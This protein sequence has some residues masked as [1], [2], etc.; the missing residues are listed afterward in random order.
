MRRRAAEWIETVWRGETATARGVQQLLRPAAAVYGR[1]VAWRNRRYD[2]RDAPIERVAARVV[3][4]GNLTVGGSGKTPTALWVAQGAAARGRRA[5]I[6]ARGYGKRRPGVVIVSTG[7][8]PLVTAADGGDEA[9]MLAH[10]FR[11]P[12]VTAERRVEAAQCAIDR[13]GAD[14]VVL[15]DGFQH[16]ALHRDADL[17]L[18]P[19][20]GVA[21]WLLPAGPFREGWDA[22]ARATALLAIGDGA[23][24]PEG[25]DRP[26]FQA[27]YL[28]AGFVQV[29]DARWTDVPPAAVGAGPVLAVAGIARPARFAGTLR[30]AGVAVADLLAF[31]DHHAFVASDV[32]RIRDAA[33]NRPVL[34]TEKDLV[35]LA[36]FGPWPELYALRMALEPEAAEALLDLLLGTSAPVD[37]AG[38]CR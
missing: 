26:R 4:V 27:T 35:K 24:S 21:P 10:R 19:P 7:D 33:R 18:M 20:R 16:R 31:A 6:V 36:A 9:V 2:R 34:C 29:R 23:A 1:V 3:A 28:P 25:V 37:F 32:R 5:A 30:A 14:V 17:L 15:D 13:F 12:I 38:K 22:A 11:G 8:G